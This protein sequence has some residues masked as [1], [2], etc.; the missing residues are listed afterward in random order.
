M[1][2]PFALFVTLLSISGNRIRTHKTADIRTLHQQTSQ[3]KHK[4]HQNLYF[5]ESIQNTQNRSIM[6]DSSENAQQKKT[7]FRQQIT[8]YLIRLRVTAKLSY[9]L[10]RFFWCV[11]H[12]SLA[13]MRSRATR[14]EWT[15]RKGR[16]CIDVNDE[17]IMF[18]SSTSRL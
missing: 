18:F 2:F 1:I 9:K 12:M 6:C 10:M 11:F 3:T 14:I 17:D 15:S 16:Y 5:L 8:Y 13:D 7:N 4:R